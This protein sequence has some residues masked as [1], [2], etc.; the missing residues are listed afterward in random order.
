VLQL[1][2]SLQLARLV[3]LLLQHE[4]REVYVVRDVLALE[5]ELQQV[6]SLRALYVNQ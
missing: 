4:V 5:H 6:P 3:K 2:L 1:A